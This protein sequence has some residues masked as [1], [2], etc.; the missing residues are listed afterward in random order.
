MKPHLVYELNL[1][2]HSSLRRKEAHQV[3]DVMG[4]LASN[5]SQYYKYK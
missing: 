5:N 2:S 1:S 4:F 3:T